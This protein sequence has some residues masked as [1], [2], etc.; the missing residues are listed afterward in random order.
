MFFTA[1][2]PEATSLARSIS[3]STR[4]Y[5]AILIVNFWANSHLIKLK[6]ILN[7]TKMKQKQGV[8]DTKKIK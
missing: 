7:L 4:F 2:G 3:I 6:P 5:Y 1:C 8:F